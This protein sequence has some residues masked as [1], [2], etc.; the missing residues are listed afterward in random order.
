VRTRQKQTLRGVAVAAGIV[1]VLMTL[2]RGA[3]AQEEGNP[4]SLR[5][6]VNEA[7]AN[8]RT[9][10]DAEHGR[11]GARQR[12]REAWS[13]LL[14][15]I[16]VNAT[17]QR[18]MLLQTIFLPAEFMG[19]APGEVR[20]VQIGSDNTWTA[21]LTVTQP[22]FEYDVFVGVGAAGRYEQLQEEIVRGTAQQVVTAV[23]S[24]YFSALLALEELRLTEESIA[25]V[26]QNLTETRARYTAGLVGEYDVLR[27][28]VELAT[29]SA[30]LE[31][32]QNQVA[33]AKRALL[34][35]VGLDPDVDIDL[36]GR[37]NEVNP[38]ALDLN[39]MENQE[40]ILLAGIP[41]V[42]DAQVEELVGTAQLRRT[43][44]RQ[45]QAT[46]SLEETR[47]KTLKGQ[48][49]PTLSLFT[50][51]NVQAQQNGGPKF[52]GSTDNRS[53]SA[54]AGIQVSMPIFQG[55]GRFAQVHQAEAVVRQNETRLERV[56][57]ETLNQVRTL[58][59]AAQESRSRA[60]SQRRAVAQA[61]RGYDIAS[62]EY[63]EG[64]GSQLQVTDA[65]VALRQSEYNYA[66]AIY[67]HLLARAQLELAIGMVPE[68]A[69]G[70]PA[71]W[72]QI[73]DYGDDNAR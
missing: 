8:S 64:I 45:L 42:V 15:D 9:L 13:S 46:V 49:F 50:N 44:I 38:D 18:N 69:G 26:E 34:V 20:P 36:V 21:G 73:E 54:A 48:F 10:A 59:D 40:L 24:A 11:E 30:N 56:E 27:F 33:S 19:G 41:G 58:F 67:D 62:A 5:R 55:F 4:Y 39:S 68:A 70:F 65:E 52:F 7:L 3:Q 14:P 63:R 12:V 71:S 23:R 43:D 35:E 32:A 16:S 31:R 60:Q 57:Q 37:L 51:Y 22:L 6:A 17:Y 53:T 29:V 47:V 2:P 25:R 61:Q 28:E 72:D 1:T 66:L